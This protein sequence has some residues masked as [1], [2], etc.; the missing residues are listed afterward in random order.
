[1]SA[2]VVSSLCVVMPVSTSPGSRT[3]RTLRQGAPGP[4]ARNAWSRTFTGH[5]RTPPAPTGPVPEAP[6]GPR[7]FDQI[8]QVAAPIG[9]VLG[10]EDHKLQVHLHEALLSVLGA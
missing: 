1:M 8:D 4:W 5:P 9:V 10:D 3:H 7:G 6:V 2:S